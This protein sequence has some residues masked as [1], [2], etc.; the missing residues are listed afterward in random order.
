MLF[1]WNKETEM[2]GSVPEMTSQPDEIRELA[3]SL[4]YA[5]RLDVSMIEQALRTVSDRVR[6]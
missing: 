1:M 5:K 3:T 4:Y 6:R 2:A